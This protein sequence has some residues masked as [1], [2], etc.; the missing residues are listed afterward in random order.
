[1]DRAAILGFIF[2]WPLGL[3][4]VAYLLWSGKMGCCGIGFGNWRADSN[5]EAQDLHP[6]AIE[7]PTAA[8]SFSFF[9]IAI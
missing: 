8:S 2:W 1:L 7:I 9:V 5:R 6:A 4:I 3:A